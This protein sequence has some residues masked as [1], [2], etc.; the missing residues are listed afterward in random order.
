MNLS[1][2]TGFFQ[3]LITITATPHFLV[4]GLVALIIGGVLLSMTSLVWAPGLG[5]FL[6]SMGLAFF[7][8]R[9]LNM[10]LISE[11]R[12]RLPILMLCLAFLAV[13][14]GHQQSR[15]TMQGTVLVGHKAVET[16]DVYRGG[17]TVSQHLGAPITL[18]EGMDGAPNVLTYGLGTVETVTID[19]SQA[20]TQLS[21]WSLEPLGRRY[22]DSGLQAVFVLETEE[23][24]REQFSLGLGKT[25][26]LNEALTVRLAAM[27]S[28]GEGEGHRLLIELI[29]MQ[30]VTRKILYDRAQDLETIIGATYP[31]VSVIRVAHEPAHAFYL[32]ENLGNVSTF[33]FI[34]FALLA[35]GLSL[36]ERRVSA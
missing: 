17:V 35:L 16:V 24:N 10:S 27:D 3:T 7:F 30:G 25:Q 29:G 2:P 6:I 14:L 1:R 11:S 28:M 18:V 19:E 20:R 12:A 9:Y 26:V 21:G 32:Y 4:I 33:V 34:G 36:A 31:R 5:H 13:F 8:A 23:G 22:Q 15:L